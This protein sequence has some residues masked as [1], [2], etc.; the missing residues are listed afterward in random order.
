MRRW[1]LLPV[2]AL[3]VGCSTTPDPGPTVLAAPV[4]ALPA[5]AEQ[6]TAAPLPPATTAP[7]PS[8]RPRPTPSGPA[9]TASAVVGAVRGVDRAAEV[10]LLVLDRETGTEVVSALPDRRFRSASLVKLL[11]AVDVLEAG[12][13]TATRKQ[14]ARMLRLSDDDIASALWVRRG[15]AALVT[16]AARAMGLRD[17]R[18]PAIPGRWGDVLLTARDVAGIYTHV[19]EALP[20]AD[21]ALVVDALA[22]APRSAADGFD[23]HFGIPDGLSA[24]WAV[25]QGWSDST[26]DIVVHS[27]GL[28][29]AGWRYVVV[30]LTEHPLR[31]AWSTAAKSVT[32]GA[33]TLD[34]VLR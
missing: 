17:T 25:K 34:A 19:L 6:D 30:L 1:L 20:A 16:R 14:V 29:G 4:I 9:P 22:A 11:I 21:R 2:L 13:D 8:D 7:P 24:P 31:T 26:R 5:P 27:T 33:R 10:G 28:V 18:P 23:Q 15:G 32:A 12:A 3:A